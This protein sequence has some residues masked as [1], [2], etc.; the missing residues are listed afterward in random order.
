MKRIVFIT[1]A[2]IIM[3]SQLYLPFSNTAAFALTDGDYMLPETE[4]DPEEKN[5]PAEDGD[6]S[7]T[8]RSAVI[9]P[10]EMK[11]ISTPQV[12]AGSRVQVNVTFK[13]KPGF[14]IR[15]VELKTSNDLL[16]FP[17]DIE[18]TSYK[19]NYSDKE[20]A[21]FKVNLRAR[22]D[23][24]QNYYSLFYTVTY[25]DGTDEKTQGFELSVL[26][27]NQIDET[28][29]TPDEPSRLIPK[30]IITGSRT[31]PDIVVAGDPF[32]IQITLQN[33]SKETAV[34]NVKIDLSEAGNA[35]LPSS[36]SSTLFISS[37][38]QGESCT[39]SMELLSMLSLSPSVYQVTVRLN[40][41]ALNS[42]SQ[43]VSNESISV[44]VTQI[45]QIKISP[46]QTAPASAQLGQFI[47]LMAGVY[48]IGK[49][50]VYN[51]LVQISGED[52]IL[53]ESEVFLG[54]IEQGKS[55]I[56]DTYLTAVG[57]G[58]TTILITVQYENEQ[59]DVFTFTSKSDYFVSE[60]VL[61]PAVD[62]PKPTEN[63]SNPY[64]A[65][66]ITLLLIAAG[67]LYLILTIRRRN[68][69]EAIDNKADT[70]IM[71]LF[72]VKDEQGK[73]EAADEVE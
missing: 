33:T 5:T 39:V 44:R 67:G 70:H 42:D 62:V 64:I 13:A 18:K 53:T 31:Y 3:L 6:G 50:T 56:V 45:P 57:L 24:I 26:V 7:Q 34:K 10:I 37:L 15:S 35:F 28:P 46:I 32:E 1:T 48:N 2:L 54:N 27:I 43:I 66:I 73:T 30:V 60:T 14:F 47:N 61:P 19:T 8:D 58:E 22:N 55:G 38:A 49:S 4:N 9:S 20:S 71:D 52:N 25:F 11:S 41:D 63:D 51:V 68:R 17:F 69:L 72:L 40:Y 21:L 16:V 59:G 23:A 65:I 29:E 36:G 12:N